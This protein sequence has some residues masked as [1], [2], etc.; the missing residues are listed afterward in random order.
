MKKDK[1]TENPENRENPTV[2]NT[3][4]QTKKPF[5]LEAEVGKLKVVV[6]L[7]ELAKHDAYQEQIK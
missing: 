4:A 6:P 3:K 5:N 7:S 1:N 2:R